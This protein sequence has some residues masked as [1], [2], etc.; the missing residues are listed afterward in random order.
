M[1]LLI[2]AWLCVGIAV[3]VLACL[4]IKALVWLAGA[5]PAHLI[6]R[7]ATSPQPS[8]RRSA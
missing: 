1:S 8:D 4:G 2:Y 6:H 7:D 5:R 3:A